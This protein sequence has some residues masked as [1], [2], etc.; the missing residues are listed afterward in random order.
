MK[1]IVPPS[2]TVVQ[3]ELEDGTLIHDL[4]DCGDPNCPTSSG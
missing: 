1:R 4:V 2:C 3:M